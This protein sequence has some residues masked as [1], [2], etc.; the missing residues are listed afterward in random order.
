MILLGLGAIYYGLNL[1]VNRSR[2]TGSLEVLR[3]SKDLEASFSALSVKQAKLDEILSQQIDP[4]TERLAVFDQNYKELKG[5][6][7]NLKKSLETLSKSKLGAEDLRKSAASLTDKISGVSQ[8]I[9]RLEQK[10]E[11]NGTSAADQLKEIGATVDQTVLELADMAVA[12]DE[13]KGRING[14][15]NHLSQLKSTQ[16]RQERLDEAFADMRLNLQDNDQIAFLISEQAVMDKS[17]NRLREEISAIKEQLIRTPAS[18]PSPSA[19][20]SQPA[21]PPSASQSGF[22]EQTIN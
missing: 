12:L 4:M 11:G 13:T 9:Q 15:Q 14:L 2:D 7:Q 5:S 20:G 22:Q 10:I 19:Q 18:T 1:Q 6:L 8:E 3:L 21:S 16:L 17:I